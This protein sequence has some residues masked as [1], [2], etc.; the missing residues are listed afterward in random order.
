MISN[1]FA[2]TDSSVSLAWIVSSPTR[3][4]TFVANRVALIHNELNPRHFRHISGK[5][6]PA[7]CLSRGLTPSQLIEHPLWFHGPPYASLPVSEWPNIKFD[8]TRLNNIDVPE[9]KVNVL[10]T[11]TTAP[12]CLPIFYELATRISSWPKLLRIIIYILR[13]IKKLPRYTI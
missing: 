10:N 4:Q 3:W 2:F 8:E 1:T 7:D 5:D 11:K 9:E 12:T 6:N 13:F